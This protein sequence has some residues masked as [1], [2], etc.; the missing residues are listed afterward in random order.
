MEVETAL[1]RVSWT[2]VQLRDP[3]TQYHIMSRAALGELTP[4][5]F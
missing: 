1:A 3:E 4:R 5:V 2:N